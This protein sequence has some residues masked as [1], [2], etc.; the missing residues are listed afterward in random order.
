MELLIAVI[1]EL[2]NPVIIYSVCFT[3]DLLIVA[4]DLLSYPI[5]FLLR[6]FSRSA[7][8]TETGG[9]E[10]GTP[11]SP[12]GRGSLW[13][14]RI[15]LA[16][17]A[18]LVVLLAGVWIADRYYF[19]PI[20]RWG[21]GRLEKRAGIA[22]DFASASGSFW[23]GEMRFNDLSI[24][25]D[26]HRS[27]TFD[28]TIRKLDMRISMVRLL[29]RRI[30]LE[31]LAVDGVRGS[32]TRLAKAGTK[33]ARRTF[34]ISDFRLDDFQVD[35][36]NRLAGADAKPVSIR[37]DAMSSA[38]LSSRW[39]VLQLLFLSKVT[40]AIDATPFLIHPGTRTGGDITYTW[41]ADGLPLSVLASL[42][43][44]PFTI[45]ERG[46]AN[47]HIENSLYLLP[48]IALDMGWA[49]ALEEYK[50][51]TPPGASLKE[52]AIWFPLVTYLNA[53]RG[54][55]N[56]AFIIRLNGKDDSIATSD[57]LDTVLD[58]GGKVFEALKT[59][60]SS[61]DASASTRRRDE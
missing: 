58:L 14:R 31:S 10:A 50:A 8:R 51:K 17:A 44:K 21:A 13:R 23:T 4:A 24:R 33:G 49:V 39:L 34:S 6:L 41:K 57:D 43:G 3:L 40:G 32:W 19:E 54:K 37:V 2:A 5:Q 46:H 55:L 25:R 26:N 48:E 30:R 9:G 59:D 7:S 22:V 29:W 42:A 15:L 53:K 28:V 52:K 27:S 11:P 20:L 60:S 56:L 16:A 47:V 38:L 36:H 45:F 12:I 18:G 35:Y 61:S 1:V